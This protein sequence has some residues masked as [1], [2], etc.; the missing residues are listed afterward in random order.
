MSDVVRRVRATREVMQKPIFSLFRKRNPEVVMAVLE[1]AF[2]DSDVVVDADVIHS[3]VDALLDELVAAGE[4]VPLRRDGDGDYRI[5]GRDLCRE[6][7]GDQLLGRPADT[8]GY[9]LTPAAVQAQEI[10]GRLRIDRP[11]ANSSRLNAILQ[12]ARDLS[13]LATVDRASRLAQ[14]DS[15][16]VAAR[17]RVDELTAER[18]RIAGGGEI[19]VADYGAL[20]ESYTHLDDLV[21]RLPTDLARVRESIDAEHRRTIADLRADERSTGQAV[22]DH[23]DKTGSLLLDTPEGQAF[24]GVRELLADPTRLASLRVDLD[25]ILAHAVFQEALRSDEQ[26]ALAHT[27]GR[28]RMNMGLV[29]EKLDRAMSTLSGYIVAR[30]LVSERELGRVLNDLGSAVAV[31]LERMPRA[32]IDLDVLPEGIELTYL[33]ERFDLSIAD[34]EPQDLANTWA[35]QPDPPS[36]AELV[37]LG[38]PRP[39]T[40]RHVVDELAH[41][42]GAS[43]GEVFNDLPVEFRRPVELWGLWQA[44]ASSG[45]DFG[46]CGATEEFHVVRPDGSTASFIADRIL[47]SPAQIWY[48]QALEA[49]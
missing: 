33:R 19:E 39:E 26:D 1:S 36:L 27:P 29:Q 14:L 47:L 49:S 13:R 32:V 37:A 41:R 22:I 28:L 2:P 34:P 44:A 46:S 11:L 43:L 15:D 31:V 6:L 16:I 9:L 35:E 42:P 24:Q 30:G 3:R 18:D 5:I 48:L 17:A 10:I 12:A 7:I 25:T 23:L 21:R 40:V 4:R 8:D 38:G 20:I 45:F